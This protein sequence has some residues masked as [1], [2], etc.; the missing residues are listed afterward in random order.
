MKV[1]TR[2]PW[3]FNAVLIPGQKGEGADDEVRKWSSE[4][5]YYEKVRRDLISFL[6]HSATQKIA[7]CLLCPQSF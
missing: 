3:Q 5:L 4:C 6:A 2:L 7:S 1:K